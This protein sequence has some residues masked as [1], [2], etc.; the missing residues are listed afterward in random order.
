MPITYPLANDRGSLVWASDLAVSG[1]RPT[2]LRC[3]GCDE[4]VVL[5]S[6]ARNQPHLAHLAESGFLASAHTN[7]LADC[8]VEQA[9]DV[10][11][12]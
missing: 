2:T 8:N 11:S 5:H 7:H 1:E 6:D 4:R 9:I 10:S 12:L 3:V